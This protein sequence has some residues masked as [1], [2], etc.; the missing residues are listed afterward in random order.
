MKT[1]LEQAKKVN[2]TGEYDV[3][4]VGG[5]Y[6][7]FGAAMCAARNGAKT[8]LVEQQSSLGGLVTL[9]LVALTFSYIEGIGHELFYN[10]KKENAVAGRFIDPEKAKRILEQ[11]LIQEGV[12]ILY[13]TTVVDAVMDGHTIQ[14]AIIHNKG[15]RQAILA[16]RVID[17][18]GDGDISAYAGAP[19]EVG[20]PEHNGYNMASSLVMRV[21][22][23]DMEQYNNSL[24]DSRNHGGNL[25]Q[26][27][28][29]EA[30][31]NGDFPYMIDRRLNWAVI[32]PG[33]DQKHQELCLCYAH[34]R[35]CRCTDG[36]DITRQLI[37]QREQ[38][39]MTI[40]F[41][42]KYLPGFEHA[43][44]I[45]TAPMLGVRDS[46]RI[47]GEYVLS[48]EDVLEGREF[49]DTV[50]RD[51]HHI[52]VHHPTDVG[53]IKHL[54]RHNA[55]GS[56]EKVYKIPGTYHNVPYRSL[57]PLNVDNLLVAGRCFSADFLAQSTVRLVLACLNMGQATGTA[58]AL[59]LEHNVTPRQL[60]AQV[61][62]QRLIDM[63]IRLDKK[64]TYGVANV[65]TAKQIKNEDLLFPDDPDS[66][67]SAVNVRSSAMALVEEGCQSEE[68]EQA[69][70]EK[71]L[72]EREAV[73]YTNTGGDVGSIL[74]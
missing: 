4:V 50:V 14:G 8:L 6:A 57:V 63:G 61:L 41:T 55:D 29:E 69:E 2:V 49:P 30:V 10:L 67:S 53:H 24:K 70:W 27:K 72:R 36:W 32:I 31:D 23:V 18:S 68:K 19:F 59:S 5:G 26:D 11:M 47:I 38:S 37:E 22:N 64:P 52:D 65:T 13:N 12:A 16:K 40:Q 58:A 46:R 17:T 51:M 33:R 45:D 39:E 54:V 7:G 56:E 21:G 34:S 28:I 74:E 73:G 25:W 15:G 9:G 60:D 62:R 1:V 44:L 42:R 20:S 35:N 3:L 71:R 48:I 66:E 43:W